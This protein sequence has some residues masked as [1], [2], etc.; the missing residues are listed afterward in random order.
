ML[1]S[2]YVKSELPFRYVV[3]FHV[4]VCTHLYYCRIAI[5]YAGNTVSNCF[6][7]LI[8]AGVLARM[9]GVLG[10][11]AWRWLFIIEG[12]LTIAVAIIAMVILPNYP[13]GR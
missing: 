8:A 6:G 2:W 3:I 12:C 5:L 7:G 10:I 11:R 4:C 9:E 13:K 1:T